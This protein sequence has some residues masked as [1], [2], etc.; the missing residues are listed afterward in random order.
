MRSTTIKKRKTKQKSKHNRFPEIIC[1]GHDRRS[2][3]P[4]CRFELRECVT[5]RFLDSAWTIIN[6]SRGDNCEE[7]EW[8]LVFADVIRSKYLQIQRV[9]EENLRWKVPVLM[10]KNFIKLTKYLPLKSSNLISLNC[11]LTTA[12]PWKSGVGFWIWGV[13][14]IGLQVEKRKTAQWITRFNA[15]RYLL[16]MWREKAEREDEK[17]LTGLLVFDVP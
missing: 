3:A 15:T 2:H 7:E 12:V 8:R 16:Q 6:N 11:P 9:E 10:N 1:A 13:I 4:N 17:G 5:N 14:S